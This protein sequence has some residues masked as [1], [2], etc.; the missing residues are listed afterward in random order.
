MKCMEIYDIK[1]EK[2]DGSIT[3]L[4]EY[5]GKVLVIIN[6]AT[7]CG[8]TPQY[9]ALQ[10]LYDK[11]K[12]KGLEILDF[13]CDQFGHQAPGTNEEIHA[14]CTGRFGITFPQFAKI[15]VNGDNTSELFRF[16][17]KEKKGILGE[18]IKWNFNKFIVDRNGVVV[19]RVAP[20]TEPNKMENKLK[21]LL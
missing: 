19:E 17:K 21:A 7:E 10:A 1:V 18:S 11:Y 3:N 5:K 13:P 4:H 16:L 8:L 6:S 15:D 12:D 2:M 9:T 20:K 14:A